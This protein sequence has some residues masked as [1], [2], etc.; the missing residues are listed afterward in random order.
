AEL[1][2]L[3]ARGAGPAEA[4]HA[5]T[6]AHARRACD[7]LLAVHTRTGG[8]D[9]LVSVALDPG[10]AGDAAGLVARARALRDAVGRPNLVVALPAARAGAV[11]D[12]L[13]AGIAVE[14]AGIFS[15]ARHRQVSDAFL[16][17]LERA[18]AAGHD[19]ATLAALA[20]FPLAPLDAAVDSRLAESGSAEARAM[21]GRSAP[22]HARL[23]YQAYEEGLAGPRWRALAAAGAR[24]PRPL[25]TA[26]D[27]RDPRYRDTRYVEELVAPDAVCA[28]DAATLDAVA[29]HAQVPGDRV[30][31]HYAD[32]RRLLGYLPWFGIS[33]EQV[34]ASLEA[35]ELAAASAARTALA[36]AVERELRVRGGAPAS[37]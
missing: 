35:A 34:A 24:P 1:T 7:L 14:A 19:L 9:G 21:A 28:V 37:V 23:A 17:G 32:A 31:R 33:H 26:T 11:A 2:A 6:A 16:D 18:R 29:R 3:A 25:W 30:R 20:S 12:C 4:L 22:A 8:R 13:A 15:P 10:P 5:L 36:A 27:V